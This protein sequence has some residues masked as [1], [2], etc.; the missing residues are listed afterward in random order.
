MDNLFTEEK[1]TICSRSSPGSLF[2]LAHCCQAMSRFKRKK[3]EAGVSLEER[4]AGGASSAYEALQ[5]Q[6]SKINRLR[7]CKKYDE[8]RGTCTCD[9]SC[10]DDVLLLESMI[11]LRGWY[12]CL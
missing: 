1:T 9:V 3:A 10:C 7:V 2:L 6:K 5:L 11:R 4:V 8:V 12:V